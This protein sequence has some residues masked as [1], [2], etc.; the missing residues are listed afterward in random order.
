MLFARTI[1]FLATLSNDFFLR[2]LIKLGLCR[3]ELTL[4]TRKIFGWSKFKVF[5]VD[6]LKVAQMLEFSIERVEDIVG[7]GENAVLRRFIPLVSETWD[8]YV[9]GPVLW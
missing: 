9:K 5:A 7:R 4:Y 8:C 3:K 2:V 6:K 1:S